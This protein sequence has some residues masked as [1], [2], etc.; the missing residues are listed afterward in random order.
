V[1]CVG[2]YVDTTAHFFSI[3]TYYLVDLLEDKH[4]PANSSLCRISHIKEVRHIDSVSL[5]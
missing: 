2:L 5:N 1:T 3:I 4:T